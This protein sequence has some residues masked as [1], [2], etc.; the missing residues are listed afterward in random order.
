MFDIGWT[1]LMVIGIVALIVVGPKDLPKMF[2]SLGQMTAK[3]RGMA[4][5]FQRAMDDAADASGVKDVARDLRKA[6]DPQGMGLDELN[7]MRN[8]DPLKDGVSGKS[9]KPGS[10][11]KTPPS[12]EDETAMDQIAAEMENLRRERAAK[13]AE[14]KPAAPKPAA[15]KPA[16]APENAPAATDPAPQ[17]PAAS[18]KGQA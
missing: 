7:K 17:A 6:T 8:W 5:E 16:P 3:M 12:D 11:D 1:E 18:D 15:V 10:G 14:A 9:G 2:R 13:T 4:R